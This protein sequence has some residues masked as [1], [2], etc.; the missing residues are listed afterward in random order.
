MRGR[1]CSSCG[2]CR[3]AR[4]GSHRVEGGCRAFD[5]RSVQSCFGSVCVR[6]RSIPHWPDRI[7]MW[8]F[9]GSGSIVGPS[10]PISCP[11]SLSPPA[12][13]SQKRLEFCE[14]LWSPHALKIGAC[15]PS[16]RVPCPMW[17]SSA[18]LRSALSRESAHLVGWRRE[19]RPHLWR[20]G[21]LLDPRCARGLRLL[22]QRL[23]GHGAGDGSR[24]RCSPRRR[25]GGV[26][27]EPRPIRGAVGGQD[28]VSKAGLGGHADGAPHV[29]R[30]VARFSTVDGREGSWAGPGAGRWPRRAG[31]F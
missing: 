11:P 1:W 20:R 21:R 29:W 16:H 7:T 5:P 15:D 22:R 2:R 30:A 23:Q 24:G 19:V 25:T 31:P 10:M 4:H 17:L 13:L 9:A 26:H 6:S 12:R 8:I 18:Y 3:P 27:L 14:I 28:L